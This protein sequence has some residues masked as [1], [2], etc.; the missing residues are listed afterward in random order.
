VVR[1]AAAGV[2][3]H[4][5]RERLVHKQSELEP[6]ATHNTT[7]HTNAHSSTR[8]SSECHA[9]AATQMTYFCASSRTPGRLHTLPVLEN[10]PSVTMRR[11][12]V[13]LRSYC[14]S[15]AATSSSTRSRSAMS[16]CL[17]QRT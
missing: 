15:F 7:T 5:K 1:E 10:T 9:R 12:C 4:A 11:R 14:L 8:R 16:L 3:Q 2:A 17:Y 13:L 6:G